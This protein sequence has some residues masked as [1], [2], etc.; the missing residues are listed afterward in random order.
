MGLLNAASILG[1]FA[2]H[3]L[4]V[5]L[6]FKATPYEDRA[7]GKLKKIDLMDFSMPVLLIT[8][9][10]TWAFTIAFRK[11]NEEFVYVDDDEELSL[12]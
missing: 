10:I 12:E 11:E 3:M 7:P 5:Y 4:Y 1:T 9:V 8:T 2:G 6:G